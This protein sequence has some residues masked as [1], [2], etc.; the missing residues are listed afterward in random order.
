MHIRI[1]DDIMQ[2]V[3]FFCDSYYD[4]RKH[5]DSLKSTGLKTFYLFLMDYKVTSLLTI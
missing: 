5:R 3:E 2:G 4:F 1:V